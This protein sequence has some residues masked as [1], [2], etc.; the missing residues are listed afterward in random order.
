MNREEWIDILDRLGLDSDRDFREEQFEG[1]SAVDDVCAN[2]DADK[3]VSLLLEAPTGTGKTLMY[4]GA[5]RTYYPGEASEA[6]PSDDSEV[7]VIV[8]TSGKLLQHQIAESAK[9]LGI[10]PVVL[11]GRANYLCR[12]AC[13]HYRKTMPN[14]HPLREELELLCQW[15]E[16]AENH[17]MR[18]I[19]KLEKWSK[20][21]REFMGHHLTASSAYCRNGHDG[22]TQDGCYF[23]E[24][25][26]KAAGNPLVILNHHALFSFRESDLFKGRILIADEAHAMPEAASSVLTRSVSTRQ[27]YALRARAEQCREVCPDAVTS[28]QHMLEEFATALR[29]EVKGEDIVVSTESFYFLSIAF[30][31]AEPFG[32]ETIRKCDPFHG[33]MLKELN[34]SWCEICDFLTGLG[35]QP[36]GGADNGVRYF[37]T[38]ADGEISLKYAPI[39]TAP[40]LENF[41]KQ[42]S[43]TVGLS[44]TLTLPGAAAGKEFEYFQGRCGFPAP[45]MKPLILPSPFDLK[46]QCRIFVPASGTDYAPQAEDDPELFL[47]KRI[48][49][50]GSMIHAFGGRTLSLYTAAGRLA[51]AA[52][53]LKPLFPDRV[54]AQGDGDNDALA[55]EF[56]REKGKSLLG[57]RSF[58]QGFDAQGETLSCEILEKLPFRR[59][60]DPVQEKQ[61]Q[62][63]REA[64]KDWFTTV[65]LP[66]MLMEL[67]QAFGRLIRGR[68]DRGIFILTDHRI[69]VKPYGQAVKQALGGIPVTEFTGPADL[70]RQIPGGFLPFELKDISGFD[71]EFQKEWN[72]FRETDLFRRV[73][74]LK[75]LADILKNFKIKK[76][77]DWQKTVIGNVLNGV[78]AQ[79]VI[80]PPGSGKSL[81]YQIPALM[82][83]GLT[84]VISP[85]K[86]LMQDQVIS[87]KKR[88]ITGAEFYNSDLSDAARRQILDRLDAGEI[89]L[90]YVAPERLHCKFIEKILNLKQGLSLMVIDEAHMISEAG[91]QWRPFYGELKHAWEEFGKPQLLVLTATAG[92]ET[93]ADIQQQFEIPDRFVYERSVVRE[94]VS[95]SVDI[96]SH[97]NVSEQKVRALEFVKRAEGR[98]V[99]IYCSWINYIY[100]LQSFLEG[101]FRWN[102]SPVQIEVYHTGPDN[103][104]HV[105]PSG[106]LHA[107]HLR[108]LDNR[109]QVLIAT[110]AYGMGIDKP[111]IWGVLFNNMPAS[112]EELVQGW[113][114]VC[115]DPDKLQQY[116]AAGHPPEVSITYNDKDESERRN[117]INRNFETIA[118]WQSNI[119]H[120]VTRY[121]VLHMG[122][123][124]E[125]SCRASS[126]GKESAWAGRDIFRTA[127]QSQDR[128][129]EDKLA[130]CIL[131]ARYMRDHE[132]LAGFGFDWK[133]SIFRFEGVSA[134]PPVTSIKNTLLKQKNQQL[135][136][137]NAVEQFCSEK[138]CRNVLLENYFSG[139]SPV[140]KCMLCD[141]CVNRRL[142]Y[143]YPGYFQGIKAAAAQS[144]SLYFQQGIFQGDAAAFL[145][146]LRKIPDYEIPV[147]IGELATE[148]RKSGLADNDLECAAALLELKQNKNKPESVIDGFVRLIE[149]GFTRLRDKGIQNLLVPF[150]QACGIP[151]PDSLW[152]TVS[153]LYDFIRRNRGAAAPDQVTSRFLAEFENHKQNMINMIRNIENPEYR[154]SLEK[155]IIENTSPEFGEFIRESEFTRCVYYIRRGLA[156]KKLLCKTNEEE[157]GSGA[158]SKSEEDESWSALAKYLRMIIRWEKEDETK[159]RYLCDLIE[160]LPAEEKEEWNLILV[161]PEDYLKIAEAVPDDFGA[162]KHWE[163]EWF[164]S[165]VLAQSQMRRCLVNRENIILSELDYAAGNMPM[166]SWHDLLSW[167]PWSAKLCPA[168]KELLETLAEKDLRPD[169]PAVP[170]ELAD[171]YC[172]LPYAMTVFLKRNKTNFLPPYSVY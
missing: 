166:E 37:E 70:L 72:K 13:L 115:R 94:Q 101:Y 160:T 46:E 136:K 22:N 126:S 148:Q 96:V 127:A 130:A 3:P 117:Q 7:K 31:K 113:G 164:C 142:F 146:Y 122:H 125:Y 172:K 84:L 169:F 123:P 79:F 171:R 61:I 107:R 29:N 34:A 14:D 131:L 35:C 103:F 83:P 93:K 121:R 36:S 60:D 78:P 11:M 135:K 42:W 86:A 95:I 77:H 52:A 157:D 68:D 141:N 65:V 48:E 1:A 74:G 110:S 21:F 114:R 18:E 69:S 145:Q 8:S 81:T 51:A 140:R 92:Q 67:R 45:T 56:V 137:L 66:A 71:G 27:L 99:L 111:D 159:F 26:R 132:M 104:G 119:L 165:S 16:I 120:P 32:S 155:W 53:V 4:L 134:F 116:L 88:G 64:K 39:E 151:Q 162:E 41:W 73:T 62:Q 30:L 33:S 139:P 6:S 147:R 47:K 91:S 20:E 153:W 58:F 138:Q 49:L 57:T 108:F 43:G 109:T 170:A 2:A 152:K 76:L 156:L 154:E 10:V 167:T 75:S 105:I 102:G 85:L 97:W 17:E 44:A 28:F 15:L 25:E 106:E 118:E 98:P 128:L 161:A 5:L 149:G 168:W 129:D 63:A 150:A 112:M 54:L 19:L 87:L 55:D 23:S 40:L 38:D 90:L 163:P 124:L 100:D 143:A 133:K 82:R 80:Q 59:K 12:T 158:I 144:I 89:R 9:K 24:L 50:A